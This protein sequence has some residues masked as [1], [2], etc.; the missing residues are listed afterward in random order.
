MSLKFLV[1]V[2]L[3]AQLANVAR[4]QGL[5][6]TNASLAN[7][8]CNFFG[9]YSNLTGPVLGPFC[10]VSINS[11]FLTGQMV[12][13]CSFINLI[14]KLNMSLIVTNFTCNQTSLNDT[15]AVCQFYN[16]NN[17]TA[18]CNITGNNLMPPSMPTSMPPMT[19][20]QMTTM[21]T[22]PFVDPALLYLIS[23]IKPGMNI[24]KIAQLVKD[25]MVIILSNFLKINK[26]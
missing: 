17:T 5:L 18:V 16:S 10:N 1:L 22:T 2:L 11:T 13:S 24:V 20:M 14:S 15:S 21:S 4:A 6:P 3:T 25:T 19:T 8:S 26:L 23:N 7:V 9:V 12:A